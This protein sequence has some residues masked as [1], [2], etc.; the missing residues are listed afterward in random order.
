MKYCLPFLLLSFLFV[1]CETKE[2]ITFEPFVMSNANCENCATVH[3]AIPKA[4]DQTQIAETITIALREEI[5]SLLN[6][7]EQTHVETLE[8]AMVSFSSD[9]K[10]LKEK[11]PEESTPWEAKIEGEVTF[12]SPKFLTIKLDSYIFT[13]GA[14][15][16]GT[17]RFL[18]FDVENGLE[19]ENGELFQNPEAFNSYA[20]Q[21]FREQE[22]IPADSNINSTGFMFEEEIFTLPAN[23]GYMSDGIQLIY[24]PYEIASYADGPILVTLPFEEVNPYLNWPNTP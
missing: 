18:N 23:I 16:Y 20:E 5:I 21:K 15:G 24:E 4:L 22:K 7:D 14:H 8:D 19:I 3:I 1:S 9:Y 10:D 11:F 12:E 6:F 17:V 2:G 13:G